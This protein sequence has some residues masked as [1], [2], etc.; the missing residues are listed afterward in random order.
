MKEYETVVLI[1]PDVGDEPLNKLAQRIKQIV[2]TSGGKFVQLSFWGKKKLAYE[3]TKYPKA[4]Y[5]HAHY[6][7]GS[8][9]PKELERNLRISEDVL[10]YMTIFLKADVDAAAYEAKALEPIKASQEVEEEMFAPKPP[11]EAF[12]D[13]GR[14]NDEFDGGFEEEQL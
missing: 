11:D 6:V 12:Q 3:I 7:G 9:L 4:V 5:L 13:Y 2:D 8:E 10:R 1:K 14:M